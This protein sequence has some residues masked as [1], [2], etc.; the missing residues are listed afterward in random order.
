MDP[1]TTT[2]PFA[3]G[4]EYSVSDAA[5]HLRVSE[6]ALRYAIEKGRLPVVRRLGRVKVTAEGV[7]QFLRQHTR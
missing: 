4:F 5:R 7:E 1:T 2:I 3:P 6:P